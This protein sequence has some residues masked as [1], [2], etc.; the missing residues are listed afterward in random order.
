M[1]PGLPL[2]LSQ[3]LQIDADTIDS[4]PISESGQLHI[5]GQ[6]REAELLAKTSSRR[7]H[8]Q[9]QNV[10]NPGRAWRQSPVV[11]VQVVVELVGNVDIARGLS[12]LVAQRVPD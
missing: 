3:V 5:V 10:R 9:L 7:L 2:G 4:R 1:L 8:R 12:T 11:R 6:Q